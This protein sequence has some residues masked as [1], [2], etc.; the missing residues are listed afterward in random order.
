MAYEPTRVAEAP[1]VPP[2]VAEPAMRP[3]KL[4]RILAAAIVSSLTAAIMTK[5]LGRKAG[6]VAFFVSASIHEVVEAPLAQVLGERL[7]L[8]TP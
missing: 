1:V 4:A 2:A 3:N 8:M 5:L 6:F 7:N